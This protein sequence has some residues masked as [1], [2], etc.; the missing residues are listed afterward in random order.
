MGMTRRA[1]TL[2]DAIATRRRT[3]FRMC[4]QLGISA[5]N[6]AVIA[7]ACIPESCSTKYNQ[8]GEV[9]RKAL[10]ENPQYWSYAFDH[11]RKIESSRR[12]SKKRIDGS[13]SKK[14]SARQKAE[15]FRLARELGWDSGGDDNLEFRVMR[16]AARQT[17]TGDPRTVHP[18]NFLTSSQASKVIQGLKVQVDRLETI[19]VPGK[20]G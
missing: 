2:K 7:D 14:A 3:W 19:A 1:P 9:S 5:E 16:F 12:K 17:G 18:L 6:Q 8:N 10:F 15:I 13:K 4:D 20:N 11:L